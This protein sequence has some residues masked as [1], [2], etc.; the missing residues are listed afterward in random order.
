MA[1][2][3]SKP[4]HYAVPIVEHLGLAEFFETVGGDELDGSLANKALVIGQV[5]ARLGSPDPAAV[6]MVG[7]RSHD[8]EGARAHGIAAIGAGWGYALAGGV[9]RR[10]A[11]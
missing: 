5:L 4:E 6:L 3:T 9:G 7:D 1:V 8:V 10:R 11:R 2:A